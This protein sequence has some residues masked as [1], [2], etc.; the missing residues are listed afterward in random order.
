MTT[1]EKKK[2]T[3]LEQTAESERYQR[4]QI[5]HQMFDEYTATWRKVE[6]YTATRNN[7]RPNKKK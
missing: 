4:Q 6:E 7:M 2:K 5:D 1:T 3:C